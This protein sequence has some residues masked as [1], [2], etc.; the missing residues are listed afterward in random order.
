MLLESKHAF[1]SSYGR[2]KSENVGYK[3]NTTNANTWLWMLNTRDPCWYSKS[4]LVQPPW[5]SIIG[6]IRL[7]PLNVRA[8][9]CQW[10]STNWNKIWH[11][12]VNSNSM[13]ANRQSQLGK[14]ARHG[15]SIRSGHQWACSFQTVFECTH[16][17]FIC[18]PVTWLSMD[19]PWNKR[20]G[21]DVPCHR[22]PIS[23]SA[24]PL[25]LTH[26]FLFLH[27]WRRVEFPSPQ[28]LA[29]EISLT[30]FAP[31]RWQNESDQ[32]GCLHEHCKVR[33]ATIIVRPGL[34]VCCCFVVLGGCAFS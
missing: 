18:I 22:L 5:L 11:A 20:M 7:A 2:A 27:C 30:C 31:M 12:P 8:F 24:V 15:T 4:I 6:L 10:T 13:T 33:T 26:I 17:C 34:A 19:F 1:L 9:L 29:R 21:F 3:S 16:D 28:F 25:V 32:A 23:R 14:R